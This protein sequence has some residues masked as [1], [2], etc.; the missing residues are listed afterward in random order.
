[1]Y[2]LLSPTVWKNIM[3]ARDSGI[4]NT[5]EGEGR[6]LGGVL[7]LGAGDAGVLYEHKEKTLGGVWV[8]GWVGGVDFGVNTMEGDLCC[9]LARVLLGAGDA[10]VLY[11]HR[12]GCWGGCGCGGCGW[13]GV[14]GVVWVDVNVG[15]GVIKYAMLFA[16]QSSLS[17]SSNGELL[18]YGN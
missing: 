15:V 12:C 6:Y 14:E 1:L 5:M 17:M 10:G 8:E 9:L 2:G 7:L 13:G 18:V 11:E 16:N 4:E 3:R